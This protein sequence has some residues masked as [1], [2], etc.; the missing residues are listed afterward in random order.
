[1][2]WLVNVRGILARAAQQ[3]PFDVIVLDID[4]GTT[5]MVKDENHQLYS[6]RGMEL[7]FRA[8]K[9]GGRAA[10]WSACPDVAIE[11]R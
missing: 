5:A 1:M 7:I 3:Q 8:L 9:P 10:V 6:E 2:D 11:R 4:N